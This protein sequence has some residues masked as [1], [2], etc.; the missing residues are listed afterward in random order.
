MTES[1][2]GTGFHFVEV[3]TIDAHCKRRNQSLV[4]DVLPSGLSLRER[5][6]AEPYHSPHS[7]L[8]RTHQDWATESGKLD[9][10]LLL[11]TASEDDSYKQPPIDT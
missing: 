11:E 7:H 6:T 1:A 3:G 8:W 10:Q 2:P 5:W 9:T 4:S